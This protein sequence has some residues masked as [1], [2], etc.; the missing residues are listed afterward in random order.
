MNILLTIPKPERNEHAAIKTWENL[1]A[2]LRDEVL[3]NKGVEMLS[4]GV[5]LILAESGLCFFGSS[6]AAAHEA[7][8]LY[9]SRF[10]EKFVLWS[11]P[12]S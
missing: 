2:K 1:V 7:N 3:Q 6:V 4:E 12:P 9:E 5:F 8:L 11:C 10:F